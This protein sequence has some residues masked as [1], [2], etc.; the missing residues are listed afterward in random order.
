MLLSLDQPKYLSAQITGG[1]GSSSEISDT[2]SWSP[3]GKIDAKY[4]APY[5]EQ[6]DTVA[7]GTA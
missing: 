5:L 3:V 2:P 1:H 6:R 4:L 7:G